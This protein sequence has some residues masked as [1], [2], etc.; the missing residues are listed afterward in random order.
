MEGER[1]LTPP[2]ARGPAGEG[3]LDED[4]FRQLYP[5]HHRFASVVADR[6][7]DP[8]DLVQ[9]ALVGLLRAPPGHVR[10]PGAY[11]R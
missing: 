11:L 1:T 2:V 10:D 9:D 7:V 8:D 5:A 4:A 3:G 6:D